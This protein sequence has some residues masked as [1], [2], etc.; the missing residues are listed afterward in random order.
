MTKKVAM[1]TGAGQGIGEAI[2]LRL[3]KDG[4][5]V[6]L[7]ARRANKLEDVKQK[8][9][10]AGGEALV[11]AADV[12]KREEIFAAVEKTVEHFGDFNDMINNAGVAPTT[13]IDTITEDD[14]DYVYSV[15]V[16]GTIFGIQAAHAAFKQVGHPGKIINATS[17]AGVVGNPNL[18]VYSRSKFAI[19]GITQV[20]AR[21]LA[22]EGTTVNAFAPG[23]VKTPMMYDI[24]HKVGQ[25]AGKDDEWG[26]QTFAKDIALKRL[27]E[28]EDVANAVA[29]LAGPDSDYITG[30]T[31]EVDGGMQFH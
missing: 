31:L 1:V 10:Q 23:I 11:V 13:P 18:T 17:Q 29:F 27:S 6:A 20:V 8:I 19:R 9:E 2:A 16:A 5:A 30:Q 28:P 4:F 3:A 21:E 22:E 7:V 26:M 14:I 15:N 25:N 12:A 24:A